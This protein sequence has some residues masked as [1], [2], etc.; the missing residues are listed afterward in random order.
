MAIAVYPPPGPRRERDRWT[1]VL[2]TLTVLAMLAILAV[3]VW[4]FVSR[5]LFG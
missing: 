1:Y 2:G 4:A 3:A 5:H